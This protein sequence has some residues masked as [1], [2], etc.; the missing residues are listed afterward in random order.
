MYRELV[1]RAAILLRKD[2]GKDLAPPATEEAL[3]HLCQRTRDELHEDLPDGYLDFLR[4]TDGLRY[5]GLFLYG[6]DGDGV[7][8]N[9]RPSKN[10]FVENNLDWRSYEER[11]KYLIFGDGDISLYALNL[12]TGRYELQDR[13]SGSIIEAFDTFDALAAEA[14]RPYVQ[15]DAEYE[16]EEDE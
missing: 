15:D 9:S 8:G 1:A 11:N 2:Y 7:A 10:S 16:D 12:I 3:A 14:L 13:P 5:N 4:L 6:T